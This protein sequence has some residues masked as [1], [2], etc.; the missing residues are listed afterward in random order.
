MSKVLLI[1]VDGKMP[2]LAL[3]KLSAYHKKQGDEVGF[4]VSNPDIVYASVIFFQNRPNAEGIKTW[5]PDA[6]FHLG[7]P[8]LQEP[9]W[10]PDEIEHIMPDYSLY[11]ELDYSM[12][13]TTRGCIRKCAFCV[14]PVLEGDFRVHAHISEFH[15][16]EFDKVMLMDNNFTAS[17]TFF[18]SLDYIREHDLK[19]CISQGMDARILTD[20]KAEALST[21][22]SYNLH[23]KQRSYI[24]AWD[25]IKD[26]QE[27]LLGLNKMI[28]AGVNPKHIMVYVLVGFD[29]KH[30]QDVYRL[31]TLSQLGVKPYVMIYNFDRSDKILNAMAKW[32]NRRYYTVCDILDFKLFKTQ[33]VKVGIYNEL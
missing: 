23:F 8:G 33:A 11:P 13:F 10:L 16:P 22:K 26:G 2:N 12:G 27:V 1:Q 29:S 21:V 18:E 14:V 31:K 28:K 7:G 6:E 20:E 15:N 24:F 17:P 3:M 32:A 30:W 19:V 25:N 4:N 9:N 5:Y